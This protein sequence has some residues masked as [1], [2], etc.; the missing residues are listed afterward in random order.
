MKQ[1]NH[2]CCGAPVE[3]GH[4]GTCPNS[5]MQGG[6]QFGVMATT[7]SERDVTHGLRGVDILYL[8][9]SMA[10]EPGAVCPSCGEKTPTKHALEMRKWRARKRDDSP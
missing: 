7:S 6:E 1:T 3:A 5:M 4:R 2:H 9:V 8:Y 10:P